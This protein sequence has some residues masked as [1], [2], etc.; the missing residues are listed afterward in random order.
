MGDIRLQTTT[1]EVNRSPADQCSAGSPDSHQV[2]CPKKKNKK[3]KKKMEA[4]D[5]L[6]IL[7]KQLL[8]GEVS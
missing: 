5:A 3:N 6:V 4:H 1:G 2:V 7:H 8:Y